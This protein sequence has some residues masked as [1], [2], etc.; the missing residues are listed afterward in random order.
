MTFELVLIALCCA[1]EPLPLT[2]YI[3]TLSTAG[4]RRNGI[5]FIASWLLTLGLVIAITLGITGGKPPAPSTAPSDAVLAVK[6]ALGVILIVFALQYRRRPEK[7]HEDPSWMKRMDKM[8]PGSAM[9]LAF[10]LQP[11]GLVAAAAVSLTAA[12]SSKS[13]DVTSIAAFVFL[14]TLPYLIMQGYVIFAPEAARARLDGLREWIN[15]HRKAMIIYLSLIIGLML[16]GKGI[17]SLAG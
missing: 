6:I 14:A 3:L 5:A 17:A 2:G 8:S 9:V 16:I 12:D 1:L 10:L 7:A 11:W 4:G 13:S 15:T